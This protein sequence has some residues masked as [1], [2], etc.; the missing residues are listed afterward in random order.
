MADLIESEIDALGDD[1]WTLTADLSRPALGVRSRPLY[2]LSRDRADGKFGP[3]YETEWDLRRM[4]SACRNVD[5]FSSIA[6]GALETLAGYV[7]GTGYTFKA[8]PKPNAPEDAKTLAAAV[9]R[10]LDQFADTNRITGGLDEEVH[11]FSRID[12]ERP[13]AVY[14]GADGLPRLRSIDPNGITEPRSVRQ[15]ER[16]YGYDDG[17]SRWEFGVHTRRDGRT[18]RHDTTEV[19]GYHVLHDDGGYDWEYVERDRME[20]FRRNVPAE[21]K[22]GVSDLFK[23]LADLER[24]AKLSRNS[25]EGMAIL[26]AIAFIKE[27]STAA[28]AQAGSAAGGDT[29]TANRTRQ[30]GGGRSV[31]RQRFQPGT[32]PNVYGGAKYHPSP[33]AAMNTGALRDVSDAVLKRV[34]A[35]W[36]M[37]GYMLTGDTNTALY[38][39]VLVIGSPFVNARLRDQRWFRE[40]WLRLVWKALRACSCED[41][42]GVPLEVVERLVEIEA[43]VPTISLESA[44]ARATRQRTEIEA[45]T[46]SRQT[47][48]EENGRDPKTE[49]ERIAAERPAHPQPSLSDPTLFGRVAES[50]ADRVFEGMPLTDSY[51]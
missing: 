13:V 6:E 34:G 42:F 35:R 8:K 39:A 9:Q 12:G 47:A 37:P 26:A 33:L 2:S 7:V 46:L 28:A 23:P 43:S 30:D 27:F 18:G 36:V 25:A 19:L 1:G 10:F 40:R 22:R 14:P 50:V 5:A 4:R 3:Y 49:G 15:L 38:S 29:I 17:L 45:G 11:R 44:D 41:W 48:M 16:H 21:A 51:P 32:I 20:L 31:Q 24:E